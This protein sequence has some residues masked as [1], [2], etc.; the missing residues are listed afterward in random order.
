MTS[1]I[2]LLILAGGRATRLKHLSEN[3]PKYLMP[4]DSRKCFADVHLEW[5]HSQGFKK[6]YLSI[7]YLGSQIKDYCQDGSRWGLQ[8]KYLEDGDA[9]LGTGGAV[10]LAL[11][12]KFE[13]LAVTYGDTVLELSFPELLQKIV[14]F[15]NANSL[16][17][18]YK[19]DIPGHQCNATFVDGQFIHY[20]KLN[21][22]SGWKHID[23]GF[24]ILKRNCIEAFSKTRPLDLALPMHQD[25]VS[26]KVIGHEV[27]SRFWEIGSPESL[28]EFQKKFTKS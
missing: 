18:V 11:S 1:E 25:S 2:P 12:E 4:I 21:A 14:S 17:T 10:A 23:Y 15:P 24:L 20:D 16:M 22:Q 9:P 26:K 27:N 6:V 7:G 19:C 3:T 5:V 8:I 28:F 13:Y